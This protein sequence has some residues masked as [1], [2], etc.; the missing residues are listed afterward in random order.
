MEKLYKRRF[1]MKISHIG[2][3]I[4]CIVLPCIPA[5]ILIAGIITGVVLMIYKIFLL[6][7]GAGNLIN[8]IP[9]EWELI[10]I[11]LTLLGL[12][13]SWIWFQNKFFH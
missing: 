1:E 2:V 5:S 9:L 12:F 13:M 4:L 8:K 6:L 10:I 11:F 7:K 3:V